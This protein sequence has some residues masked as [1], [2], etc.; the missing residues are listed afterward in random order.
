MAERS[1]GSFLADAIVGGLHRKSEPVVST[2]GARKRS[3]GARGR[4][5]VAAGVN[6]HFIPNTFSLALVIVR[7]GRVWRDRH[8]YDLTPRVR[9]RRID[10]AGVVPVVE[11]FRVSSHC[12]RLVPEAVGLRVVGAEGFVAVDFWAVPA[13]TMVPAIPA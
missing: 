7:I 12:I 5:K 13:V 4:T 10:A 1:D 8:R 11:Q 2:I 9:H 6:A 3:N